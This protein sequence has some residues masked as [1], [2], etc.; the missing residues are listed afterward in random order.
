MFPSGYRIHRGHQIRRT[1]CRCD[2]GAHPRTEQPDF[3]VCQM[4][5][6]KKRQQLESSNERTLSDRFL[7]SAPACSRELGVYFS[8]CIYIYTH[9]H[10]TSWAE[11]AENVP[12]C[13]S[14]SRS[15]SLLSLNDA[16][17]RINE[18]KKKYTKR[19]Q[20]NEAF[21]RHDRGR[22]SASRGS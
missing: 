13:F 6:K 11:V 10:T 1:Y 19:R 12:F 20:R 18:K 15:T 3:R 8:A 17:E 14:S 7:W 16:C 4:P 22:M 2:S 5:S 9:T 21:H